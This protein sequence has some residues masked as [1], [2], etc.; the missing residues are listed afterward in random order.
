LLLQTTHAAV[1]FTVSPNLVGNT[2]V[3]PITFTITGLTNTEKVVVQNFADLNSS[4]TIDGAD[5]M[6]QQYRLTDGQALTFSGQTNLNVPGDMNSATGALTAQFNFRS[7]QPG[8]AFVGNYEFRLS[9]PSGRFT[10][11]TNAFTVTNKVLGQSF[12]G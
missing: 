4:G 5:L 9:S 1:N 7:D 6:V 3:G 12:S 10:P 2:Y 11:L 8:P